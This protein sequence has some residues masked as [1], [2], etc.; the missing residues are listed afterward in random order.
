M[1]KL[2]LSKV[3][4][5]AYLVNMSSQHAIRFAASLHFLPACKAT[6]THDRMVILHPLKACTLWDNIVKVWQ[7]LSHE[8]SKKHLDDKILQAPKA[9]WVCIRCSPAA[10]F[11]FYML[12]ILYVLFN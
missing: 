9:R 5:H 10:L 11:M 12:F 1:R 2:S 8:A 3:D 6:D 7:G 4:H